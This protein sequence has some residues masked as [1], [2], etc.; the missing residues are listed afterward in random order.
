MFNIMTIGE[1]LG[2]PAIFMKVDD[3]KYLVK[4]PD[5]KG[6][7]TQGDTLESAICMAQEA[8][9][10]YYAEKKGELPP[11]SSLETIKNENQGSIVQ[12]VAINADS[13]IIRPLRAVKKTL[14]IPEW[15][16][17]LAEKYQVNFSGILKNALIE[18]LKNLD[19]ISSYDRKMLND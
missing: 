2:Y 10:I 15:L 19:S 11:A 14:T 12:V 7:I 18:Y 8:L 13:Y 3:G 17:K 5:L 16:N 4:F 9:A 1:I 6:C